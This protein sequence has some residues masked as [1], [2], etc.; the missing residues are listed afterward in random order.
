MANSD[1]LY[2]GKTIG[3]P[4]VIDQYGRPQL[5]EG[6]DIIPQSI[7]MILNTAK[8]SRFFVAQYGSDVDLL[9]FSPN[10][11]VLQSLLFTIIN[12]ALDIW[13]KRIKV[14]DITFNLDPSQPAKLD[15]VIQYL[16]IKSNVDN[17]FVY[18]FYT[19]TID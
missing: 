14:L 10:D 9:M 1:T 2:L 17:T 16:I 3:F 4:I 13:E 15:C 8:G 5:I 6:V 11:E 12:D 19:E 18:P 7:E